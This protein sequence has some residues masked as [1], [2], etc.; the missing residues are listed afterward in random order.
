M[1]IKLC[2][3]SPIAHLQE[4][5]EK[6]DMLLA[7]PHIVNQSAKYKEY[8]SGSNKKIILDSGVIEL[9]MP[10]DFERLI[11][12]GEDVGASE[13]ALPDYL[14][15]SIKTI[16]SATK[17]C[18]EYCDQSRIKDFS[19]MGIVQGNCIGEWLNCFEQLASLDMITTLGIGIYSVKM[20]FS[21]VTK[22][23]DC[24][25]NRLACV[26][27]LDKK[28]MIPK[29]KKLHLLGL[30]EPRELLY[31][32][33]YPFINSC[34]TT[35]PIVYGLQGRRYTRDGLIMG[36]EY[37]GPKMNYFM[38]IP[39]ENFADIMFNIDIVKEMAG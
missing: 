7:L 38:E 6:G 27:I 12:I 11:E 35:R 14:Y 36:D 20:A 19:F 10:M 18:K 22:K 29:G 34:D 2:I 31:Q 8:Y 39:E 26:E 23:Q 5:S 1:S 17:V 4:F 37:I 3:M 9:G 32:K 16:E 15:D 13:I 33:E 28:N 21:S 25:R 30:G 24:L